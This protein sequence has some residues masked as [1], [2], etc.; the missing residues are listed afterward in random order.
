MVD[1]MPL[2]EKHFRVAA[3]LCLGLLLILIVGCLSWY[4]LVQ[5]GLP[6][7]VKGASTTGGTGYNCSSDPPDESDPQLDRSPEI[8]DR[9]RKSFP[10]GSPASRLRESLARQG[11]KTPQ[12][13]PRGY[14]RPPNANVNWAQYRRNGNEVV[15][16]VY[17]RE[18]SD[19][20]IIWT[21]A[22]VGY[23]FI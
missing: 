2:I 16:N 14:P 18:T 19:G 17:W 23:T 7:L 5:I 10:P 13:C 1:P 21:F 22:D 8:I 6:P 15:A 3:W 20:R 12:P 9:L 4:P 11:F